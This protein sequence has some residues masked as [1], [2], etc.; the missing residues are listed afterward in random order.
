MFNWYASFAGVVTLAVVGG[1]RKTKNPAVLTPL[2]PIYFVTGYQWDMCYNG[3]M[4]R[5]R[6]KL[7]MCITVDELDCQAF[8]HALKLMRY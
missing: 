8:S 4:K 2:L 1:F 6:G 7:V 3:K 5:I